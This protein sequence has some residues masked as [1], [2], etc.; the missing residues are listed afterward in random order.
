MVASPLSLTFIGTCSGGGPS[1]SRNCTATALNLGNGQSWL[2]DCAEATQHKMLQFKSPLPS[3]VKRVFITH[4]HVDHVSGLVPLMSTIMF[5]L[6][7]SGPPDTIRLQ[8]YGPAGLRSFVR[9]N[10]KAMFLQLGGKYEVNELLSV[11]DVPTTNAPEELHESEAPGRDFYAGD[12]GTW[13]AF[14]RTPDGWCISAGPLVHRAPCVGYIFNEPPIPRAVSPEYLARLNTI[15]LHLL[16]PGVLQPRHLLGHLQA[17]GAV[18]LADGVVLEPPPRTRGRKVVVLGDTC[19]A[20]GC[21][22][23]AYGAD[24]LVHEATNAHV[25]RAGKPS[26]VKN[27]EQVERKAIGRGHSTPRMA[28]DFA[29]RINARGLVMNHF[30][31][32]FGAVPMHGHGRMAQERADFMSQLTAQAMRAFGS[33]NVIAAEDGFVLD[34][35]VPEEEERWRPIPSGHAEGPVVR[36]ADVSGGDATVLG[37]EVH[38]TIMRVETPM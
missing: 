6:A 9:N 35:P 29:R 19:D 11:D 30:S 5:P 18:T 16:P 22:E 37:N 31:S 2:I 17:E 20:S 15:P 3:K 10:L 13:P 24:A 8:V 27:H 36:E 28:G 34:I 12:D 7:Y 23:M 1:A 21:A 4:M 33:P 26:A 25:E 32:R 14:E 38:G